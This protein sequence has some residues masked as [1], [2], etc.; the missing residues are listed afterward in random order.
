MTPLDTSPRT[1]RSLPSSGRLRTS[2]LSVATCTPGA[3]PTLQPPEPSRA[4]QSAQQLHE[5]SSLVR[6]L[7]ADSP[8]LVSNMAPSVSAEIPSILPALWLSNLPARIL[9][10]G[11]PPSF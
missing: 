2:Q 3:E 1:I 6:L 7:A 4:R 8:T 11:I 5:Q 9:A 10:G